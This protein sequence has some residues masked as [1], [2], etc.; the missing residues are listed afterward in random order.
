METRSYTVPGITCGHCRQA[1]TEELAKVAGIAE[2][3][4]DLETKRV[5]VRGERLDDAVLRSAIAEAGYEA[6]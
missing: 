2:V 4:V 6:A 5:L 3:D 1:L